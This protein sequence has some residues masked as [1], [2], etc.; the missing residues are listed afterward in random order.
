MTVTFKESPVGDSQSNG[1]AEE[2][3][4]VVKGLAR[5]NIAH[6]EELHGVTIDPTE[7]A[8]AWAVEYSAQMY[9]RNQRGPDGHTPYY[10]RRKREYKRQ[11]PSWSEKVMYQISKEKKKSTAEQKY[12]EGIF[13]ALVDR[14]DE[15]LVGTPGGVVK[16]RCIRR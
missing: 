5:T 9:N 11:L 4:Q 1:L 3:V 10:R 12:A 6:A 8:Q 13:L 7:D 14:S 2:A 16:T 15:V